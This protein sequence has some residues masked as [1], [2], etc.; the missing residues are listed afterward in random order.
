MLS[1]AYSPME[2]SA[3]ALTLFARERGTSYSL[4]LLFAFLVGVAELAAADPRVDV[5]EE[6]LRGIHTGQQLRAEDWLT[7]ETRSSDAFV[8]YGGLDA[9]IRQ[10]T[11][12]ANRNG[13]LKAV[14][15][16]DSRSEGATYLVIAEVKF[17][18][19][20]AKTDTPATATHE[21]MI[22]EMRVI[23]EKG[24]WKLTL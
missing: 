21:R 15:I 24:T 10:G 2:A 1:E 20:P 12:R 16:I 19:D 7:E 18:H 8:A 22:W 3:T 17:N 9:L 23:R 11:A 4:A 5:A 13:G 6:F 14:R